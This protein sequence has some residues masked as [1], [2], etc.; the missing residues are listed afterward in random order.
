[1]RW[2]LARSARARSRSRRR[3]DRW[4]LLSAVS[5][6]VGDTSIK[7]RDR[8][9]LRR[10]DPGSRSSGTLS[11]TVALTRFGRSV[12]QNALFL[13][14]SIFW[15]TST[16]DSD[17]RFSSGGSREENISAP[18]QES[19]AHA[20]ISQAH[21][22]PRGARDYPAPSAQGAPAA[23]RFSGKEVGGRSW[24]PQGGARVSRARAA[25]GRGPSTWPSR[26]G[27]VA[28]WG[29]T[30]CCSRVL[31]R[32]ARTD[33]DSASRSAARWAARCCATA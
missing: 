23:D 7:S 29:A 30:T 15:R 9:I 13:V 6:T 11:P 17:C 22:D 14:N 24:S 5:R 28:S 21:E 26:A 27:A 8:T 32:Q 19:P 33:L 20:W 16:L 12:M 10:S 4:R 2:A 18:P 31:F 3:G 25:C 1:M